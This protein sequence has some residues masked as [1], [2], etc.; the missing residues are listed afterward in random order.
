M[1]QNI[2]N[3]KQSLP[4]IH[5]C[6]MIVRFQWLICSHNVCTFNEI[7][8]QWWKYRM[9][10]CG[11]TVMCQTFSLTFLNMFKN[12]QYLRPELL[13]TLLKLSIS[14]TSTFQNFSRKQHR[15]ITVSKRPTQ[16]KQFIYFI[17]C[18]AQ[19]RHMIGSYKCKFHV[20]NKS[21]NDW[22]IDSKCPG[23]YHVLGL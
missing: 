6:I 4:V 17:M 7:S 21:K 22:L 12:L 15:C 16:L 1:I 14:N 2:N 8:T 20:V 11:V 23:V 18:Y 10:K 19:A 5:P 3:T 9:L 13:H